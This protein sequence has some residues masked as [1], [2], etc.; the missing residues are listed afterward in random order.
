[1]LAPSP[2][3]LTGDRAGPRTAVEALDQMFGGGGTAGGGSKRA[4][5]R[6]PTIVL[7]DEMDLLVNKAQVCEARVV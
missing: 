3:A 6:R 4:A 2:Q 1:M 5:P 7:V